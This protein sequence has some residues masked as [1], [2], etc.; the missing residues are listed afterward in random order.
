MTAAENMRFIT[1]E[2]YLAGELTSDVKHE[3]VAGHV[4]A[5]A[6][7]TNRHNRIA[8]NFVSKLDYH[9]RD[10]SCQ[11]FNSDTKVR[12]QHTAN[13]RFYYPDGMVVCSENPSNDTFQDNPVVL[14]EVRSPRTRRT[15]EFEKYE[16]YISIPSLL[17]YLLAH[18]EYPSVVVHRRTEKGFVAELIEGIDA[19]IPLPEIDC[20]LPMLELYDR[21]D[22]TREDTKAMPEGRPEKKS[23]E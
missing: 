9:L 3:Y 7:A 16:A 6:G 14:L 13:S 4:Y 8:T 12:V 2:E 5:M 20:E 10:S 15:D 11:S 1:V 18:D 23:E 21:V 22:F 19:V 17:V